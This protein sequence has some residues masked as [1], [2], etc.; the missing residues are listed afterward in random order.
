M[1]RHECPPAIAGTMGVHLGTGTKKTWSIR[2][3][4]TNE[5]TAHYRVLHTHFLIFTKSIVRADLSRDIEI[6]EIGGGLFATQQHCKKLC[7]S[8]TRCAPHHSRRS[9]ADALQQ[10]RE[11]EMNARGRREVG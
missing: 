11:E 6:T 5:F 7:Q 3:L 9:E 1:E 8:G 10:T 2:L 4:Q